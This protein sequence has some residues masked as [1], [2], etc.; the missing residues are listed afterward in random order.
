[1]Q[2]KEKELQTALEKIGHFNVNRRMKR[3][4]KKLKDGDETINTQEEIILDL[5]NELSGEKEEIK[6]TIVS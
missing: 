2:S 6:I 3:M 5:S 1:M 4:E